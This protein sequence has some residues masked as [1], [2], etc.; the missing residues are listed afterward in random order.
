MRNLFLGILTLVLAGCG[1]AEVGAVT[2]ANA[3]L[4]AE[5][6]KQAKEQMDKIKQDLD[7][8]TKA[9]DARLKEVEAEK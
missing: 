7:A 2:A 4:Q 5:Q 1:F 3:K 9:N 8:A 6:A